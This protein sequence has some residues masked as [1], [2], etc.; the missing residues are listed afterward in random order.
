MSN[1]T[2]ELKGEELKNYIENRFE[3]PKPEIMK[4]SIKTEL[5]EHLNEFIKDNN[6]VKWARP[7]SELHFHAFNAFR[8]I[9]NNLRQR[10]KIS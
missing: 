8:R 6:L 10:R 3:T 7:D 1:Y 9:A 5:T 2:K 4:Q